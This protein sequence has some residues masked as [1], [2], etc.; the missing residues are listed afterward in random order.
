MGDRK[1]R[2]RK[3]SFLELDEQE[4]REILQQYTKRLLQI[5]ECS[6]STIIT[7]FLN[8]REFLMFI[9]KAGYIVKGVKAIVTER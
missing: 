7:K 8:I 9:E 1:L 5:S 3:L 2:S 6:L 4:D